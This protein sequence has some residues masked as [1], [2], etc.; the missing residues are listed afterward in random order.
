MKHIVSF[1]TGLSSALTVERALTRYGKEATEVVFMDTK[2]ED[3]DNYRFMNDC[4]ARWGIPITILCEGRTPYEVSR[5][6]NVIPNSLIAPCSF[7]LK[8]E[9]FRKYIATLEKPVTIHIGYDAQE[10]HRIPKTEQNYKSLGYEVDFPLLWLPTEKRKYTD[11]VRDDWG[12]EPP[13]MYALGYTHA[14]CSGLCVKQGQGD[15]IRTLINFPERY[16]QVETWEQEMRTHS[17]R[18]AV[19]AILKHQVNKESL[20]FTLKELR[21]KYER[22]YKVIETPKEQK[23]YLFKLDYNSTCVVCGIGDVLTEEVEA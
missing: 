12:I 20:P 6:E 5:S 18:H 13:R 16:A 11:V 19:R 14:N 3:D 1:S 2:M 8:I 22:E 4:K 21:E 15:W 17:E 10:M 7:R 9:I 23:M